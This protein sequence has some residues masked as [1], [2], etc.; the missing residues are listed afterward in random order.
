MRKLAITESRIRLAALRM[1]RMTTHR[2]S[3]RIL[4]R[5]NALRAR[6]VA[7]LAKVAGTVKF[8]TGKSPLL[9]SQP[10][11]RKA[12]Y[13]VLAGRKWALAPLNAYTPL[14]LERVM[15]I[16]RRKKNNDRS[17]PLVENPQPIMKRL[18][19]YW[20]TR[21]ARRK[22]P[23]LSQRDQELQEWEELFT[24][25]E[26]IL[27]EA[28]IRLPAGNFIPTSKLSEETIPKEELK[29]EASAV[30][31]GAVSGPRQNDASPVWRL[32]TFMQQ[33]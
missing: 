17:T 31:Q 26:T 28:E 11:L 24:Q 18:K 7:P 21:R 6:I 2:L 8:F 20:R 29:H 15:A 10:F 5:Y 9:F 33:I 3:H 23:D 32:D 25:Q 1:V 13:Q 19:N 22:T 16:F 14:T 30:T 27:E 12:I 4:N